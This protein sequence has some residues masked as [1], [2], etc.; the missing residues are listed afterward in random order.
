MRLGFDRRDHL[1][2]VAAV[3]AGQPDR[4]ADIQVLPLRVDGVGVVN[5]G[6]HQAF[7]PVVTVEAAAVLADL[8]QP[9]PDRRR[10]RGHGDPAGGAHRPRLDKFVAGQFGDD[11]LVGG[12]PVVHHRASHPVVQAREA[13][14]RHQ[15]A[16]QRPAVTHGAE[17]S[18]ARGS[19]AEA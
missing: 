10:R 18:H 11:F 7:Q 17:A 2:P 3:A 13:A 15:R 12:A 5:P 9:R 8:C 14:R 6:A 19:R 16:E 1:A 4:V